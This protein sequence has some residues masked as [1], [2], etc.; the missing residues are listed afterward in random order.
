MNLITRKP[1]RNPIGKS[2]MLMHPSPGASSG[3]KRSITYSAP[4]TGLRASKGLSDSIPKILVPL[5]FVLLFISCGHENSP[6]G[7]AEAFLFRYFLELNQRGALEL[8]TGLAVDKLQKEIELTQNVRMEPN[9][10]LSKHRPFI[11]YKLLNTQERKDDSVTLFYDVIIEQKSGRKYHR[12]AVLST[13]EVDGNWKINN[14]DIF[15]RSR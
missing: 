3:I 10:D 9:L 1:N 12:E 7:V 14:F 11:D 5:L 2:K 8:S 13:V 6:K 4:R 15:E